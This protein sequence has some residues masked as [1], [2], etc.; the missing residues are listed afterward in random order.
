M[1]PI[2][3]T[4]QE[5]AQAQIPLQGAQEVRPKAPN[6]V[7]MWARLLFAPL[8]L[9]LPVLCLAALIMRVAVRGQAPRVRQTWATYLLTLLIISGIFSTVLAV[10]TI[11]LYGSRPRCHQ[12][13]AF[14]PGRARK[15]PGAASGQGNVERGVKR[16]PEAAG[17]AGF[18]GGEA[19]VP[20]E[21][22]RFRS[23]GRGHDPSFRFAWIPAGDSAPRG[24]WRRLAFPRRAAESDGF[25]R[26]GWMGV[27]AGGRPPQTSGCRPAVAGT[28]F[29]RCGVYPAG[30]NLLQRADG[31][32]NFCHRPP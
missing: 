10:F 14:R 28:S 26:H 23:A 12:F 6:P 31:G 21:S 9:V 20:D 19:L 8:V 22:G 17:A 5:V 25:G 18:A 27:G 7:P 32:E 30:G 29:W 3:I 16:H 13:L 11:S 4:N 15:L 1:D 24:G 2:V